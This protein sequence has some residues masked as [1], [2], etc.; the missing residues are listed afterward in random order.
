M[1]V[2]AL[3]SYLSG[4]DPSIAVG[5]MDERRQEAWSRIAGTAADFYREA[6]DLN[7]PWRRCADRYD[8]LAMASRPVAPDAARIARR[9]VVSG[10]QLCERRVIV[11]PELPRGA[12]HVDGV[13]LVE[14]LEFLKT[15][16]TSSHTVAAAAQRFGRPEAAV[17]AAHHWLRQSG[18]PMDIGHS[19]R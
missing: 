8:R 9:A 5:F 19:G 1:L 15:G 17:R 6:T 10:D 14:L 2:T 16:S 4:D 13:P 11:T 12:W 3:K 7:G 18:V